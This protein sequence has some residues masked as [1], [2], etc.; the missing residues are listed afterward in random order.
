MMAFYQI[1]NTCTNE[2]ANALSGS[3]HHFRLYLYL[4]W[5]RMR[6]R[7]ALNYLGRLVVYPLHPIRSSRIAFIIELQCTSEVELKLL[8]QV[9]ASICSHWSAFYFP[10]HSRHDRPSSSLKSIPYVSDGIMWHGSSFTFRTTEKRF[11]F[12]HHSLAEHILN[13]T[14]VN[15]P[16]AHWHHY[17]C[18]I[19]IG[20]LKLAAIITAFVVSLRSA[21]AR[22]HPFY[23]M[24]NVRAK[25]LRRTSFIQP[26]F[27]VFSFCVCDSC[28]PSVSW[29][30]C[31]STNVLDTGLSYFCAVNQNHTKKWCACTCVRTPVSLS[32]HQHDLY[33]M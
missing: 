18:F 12:S 33:G 31:I 2:L 7:R 13:G 11:R 22:L 8:N 14:V 27:G 4:F 10:L 3:R 29:T 21:V 26:F 6:K 32:E 30:K 5:L 15:N 19:C 23:R 20:V 1:Q 28:H 16:R 24:R 17:R 25:S 9:K